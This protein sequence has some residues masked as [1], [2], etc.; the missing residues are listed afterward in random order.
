VL[1]KGQGQVILVDTGYDHKEYG[2]YLADLSAPPTRPTS[3]RR[4]DWP[5]RVA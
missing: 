2:K 3:S 4:R 1:I 5:G